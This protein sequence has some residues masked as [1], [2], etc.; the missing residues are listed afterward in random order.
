[1]IKHYCGTLYLP[2]SADRNNRSVASPD[3]GAQTR[4]TRFPTGQGTNGSWPSAAALPWTL[5]ARFYG[6][7]FLWGPIAPISFPFCGTIYKL[8][9]PLPA[10]ADPGRGPIHFF[11]DSPS[12][13]RSAANNED[14]ISPISPPETITRGV[15]YGHGPRRA[16]DNELAAAAS[17]SASRP[18]GTYTILH[19][20]R[21]LLCRAPWISIS[22]RTARE[23]RSADCSSTN[24]T[25]YGT[26]NSGGKWWERSVP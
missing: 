12:R 22:G 14:G 10:G 13:C 6:T 3:S 2:R 1:M 23:R 20:F 11:T 21:S 24:G 5:Q 19:T 26:T 17:Y 15:L 7:T 9:P 16:G 18:G 4:S 8:A 25:I